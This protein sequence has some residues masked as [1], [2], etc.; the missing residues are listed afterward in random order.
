M[1]IRKNIGIRELNLMR[2]RIKNKSKKIYKE[3]LRTKGKN[4]ELS[5]W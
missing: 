2:K 5:Q 1:D 4:M 3:S